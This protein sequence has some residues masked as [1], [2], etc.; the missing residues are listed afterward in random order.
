MDHNDNSKGSSDHHQLLQPLFDSSISLPHDGTKAAATTPPDQNPQQ[1]T[2]AA[3]SNV[4]GRLPP[5][6][7]NSSSLD[8][9]LISHISTSGGGGHARTASYGT[10]LLDT[11]NEEKQHN[12]HYQRS[13]AAAAAAAVHQRHYSLMGEVA[14]VSQPSLSVSPPASST[15]ARAHTLTTSPPNILLRH[16]MPTA[17][18]TLLSSSAL[19]SSYSSS[20]LR[21]A[22][23]NRNSPSPLGGV[24]T[25]A[26]AAK[27]TTSTFDFAL[28]LDE[29]VWGPSRLSNEL[30]ILATPVSGTFTAT[31]GDS[32]LAESMM[33]RLSIESSDAYARLRSYSFNSPPEGDD[34]P[35]DPDIDVLHAAAKSQNPSLAFRKLMARTHARSKT[36]ASPLGAGDSHHHH[37]RRSV[38]GHSRQPSLTES[39][40][41]IGIGGESMR[42]FTRTTGG[43]GGAQSASHSRQ[44]SAHHAPAHHARQG[45][46]DF[47]FAADGVPTRSLWVGNV[48][49]LLSNQEL[50]AQ[51]GKY[52]RVESLRLL[53]DKE[54]AF[55][56]FL[57]VED[58]ISA[59]EDMHSGARIGNNT[60]RVGYGKGESYATGDAQAMQPT[61]ALWIGNIAAQASPDSLAHVFQQFGSIESAR[62]LNHKNCGFVNFV[63]LEDAVRAKQ[64]MNGKSIGGSVVRIG[65]AKVP[66]A[67]NESSL[68]LRNPVPSAAPL[69][70]LGQRAEE[71]AITGSASRELVLE[72][73]FALAV[74]EDLVAF[75]YATHLPPLPGGGGGGG[76]GSGPG[77]GPGAAGSD[78][79]DSLGGLSQARLRDL[80]K[81]LEP[82]PAGSAHEGLAEPLARELL[83]HAVDLCTDYVGNVLIQRLAERGSAAQRLELARR[84]GP[85]MAAIGAHKNGTWAV[86]KIIDTADASEL[87][88]V[89]AQSIRAYAPQLLLDQLGNYVVQGCLKFG[90]PADDDE[91]SSPDD[92]LSSNQF[93]FDAIHARCVEIAQGRFGARA[94]RTCLESPY[95]TRMQQKLV[96]V[97]LVTNA[98]ALATNANGHLL[99]NWLL[100]SSKFAGRFRVLA[101]QLAPHLR[102]LATH[103]LGSTTVTKLVDQT[104]EPDA[105]DLILNTLFFNPDPSVL[106]DLLVDQAQGVHLVLRILQ[107]NSIGD[108]EKARI[109]DRLRFVLENSPSL[110]SLSSSSPPSSSSSSSSSPSPSSSSALGNVSP[111]KRLADV[112]AGILA[113]SQPVY[114]PTMPPAA[115]RASASSVTS[116]PPPPPPTGFHYI[117]PPGAMSYPAGYGGMVAGSYYVDPV[118]GMPVPPFFGMDNNSNSNST[119]GHPYHQY[120][121]KDK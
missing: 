67:K 37:H 21:A 83:P 89:V 2:F 35:D 115:H 32:G 10:T 116:P 101:H 77:A 25:A 30:D 41:P 14:G 95:A 103:K 111:A 26:D 105:R 6:A 109:A 99:M 90:A 86:Q 114:P 1:Q 74:D 94:I 88:R 33:D 13:A 93:V 15:H 92:L 9:A 24:S 112:V 20:S 66:A 39:A 17:T 61:R 53:P 84:V 98:V 18:N 36:L 80:R 27:L 31:G 7:A 28:S 62:V 81:Q 75:S 97:A 48:D 5:A 42:A 113:R 118:S 79:A 23:G 117:P 49:P 60:V 59:K 119:S 3:A 91:G 108:A 58:A 54:C 68:K 16:P 82:P 47:D 110:S 45:S 51:F 34:G 107:G 11:L 87:R 40:A 121:T 4:F 57:R 56:N 50:A 120:Y 55:V 63:R 78:G 52:G 73:G 22:F 69:T 100:D 43:G 44:A 76:A 72:P 38:A 85:H 19:R 29:G 71:D 104:A 64:A 46:A 65:Y 102:Y 70:A 12:F 8:N 106:D 96:A